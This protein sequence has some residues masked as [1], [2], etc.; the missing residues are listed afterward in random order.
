MMHAKKIIVLILLIG[1]IGTAG[2]I[3]D[4]REAEEPESDGGGTWITPGQPK[5]VLANITSG[6]AAAA[7]SNYERSLHDDFTFIPRPEDRSNLGDEVF[8]GWNKEVEMAF[9]TR[10]KGIYLGE[11]LI[12]F[13]DENMVFEREDVSVGRA[14][15]EGDYV[16]TLDLGD[17]SDPEI[18]EGRAI[19]I[20]VEANQGW[21]L[22]S[23]EDVDV[24]GSNPTS[25]Y[26]RGT[27]R[28]TE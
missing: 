25:G 10:L 21:M 18:Y 3:F 16:M 6:L 14:E 26:L 8:D 13:G 2:C 9:L 5:D 20:I 7:N 22:L 1:F 27:L 11:R 23:W 24:I 4:P 19:F 12:Q 28:G 17:G 15:F